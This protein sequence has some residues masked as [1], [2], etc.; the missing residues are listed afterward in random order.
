LRVRPDRP[1]LA[2]PRGKR[3]RATPYAGPAGFGFVA[4][5]VMPA[6]LNRTTLLARRRRG[7]LRNV[8]RAV[9]IP[10][11]ILR[12]CGHGQARFLTEGTY[13]DHGDYPYNLGFKASGLP[14]SDVLIDEMTYTAWFGTSLDNHDTNCANVGRRAT[15]L[16]PP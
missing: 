10:V 11:Q 2:V 1:W 13:L 15:E 8:L 6:F 14:T 4:G 12:V 7:F 5:R 3:G 16:T 9:N